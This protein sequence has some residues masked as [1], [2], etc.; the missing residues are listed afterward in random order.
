MVR[1][2]RAVP[3][4]FQE[5]KEHLRSYVVIGGSLLLNRGR[6]CPQT[7]WHWATGHRGGSGEWGI[8]SS[9]KHWTLHTGVWTAVWGE[10]LLRFW[11]PF[12]GHKVNPT[13]QAILGWGVGKALYNGRAMKIKLPTSS[14]I[15]MSG[16]S[17]ST[18]YMGKVNSS[19]KGSI[20]MNRSMDLGWNRKFREQSGFY[21]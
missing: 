11:E 14:F 21:S 15:E 13:I 7:L 20:W 8:D 16:K 4:K 3:E 19:K 18:R 10:L 5:D 1:E 6:L 17:S 12:R 9:S 2:I